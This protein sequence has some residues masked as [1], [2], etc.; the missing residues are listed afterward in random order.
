MSKVNSVNFD[1]IICNTTEKE[2]KAR[3]ILQANLK[4]YIV[5]K[6]YLNQFIKNI[7]ESRGFI[8]VVYTLNDEIK[9]NS[10][11]IDNKRI[12][13]AASFSATINI[14]FFIN[15]DF[16][17]SIKHSID[18][19]KYK[20]RDTRLNLTNVNWVDYSNSIFPIYTYHDAP[21]L[22]VDNFKDNMVNNIYNL[23]F[24]EVGKVIKSSKKYSKGK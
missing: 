1:K 5:T 19:I 9:F 12:D 14:R 7:E 18:T 20:A 4:D 3:L 21:S 23:K 15:N 17:I 2:S 11:Q 24:T 6:Y 10:Y 8:S 16:S 13:S 22:I